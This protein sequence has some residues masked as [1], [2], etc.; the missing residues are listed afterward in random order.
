MPTIEINGFSKTLPSEIDQARKLQ[1]QIWEVLEGADYYE[2]TL[3][4]CGSDCVT[5]PKGKI[6]LLRLW[7][8]RGDDAIDILG[9]LEPLNIRTQVSSNVMTELLP[10]SDG[11]QT[12]LPI[13]ANV[14]PQ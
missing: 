3:L 9:R 1:R 6:V 12:E 2:D 11:R 14:D 10:V 7:L 13:G 8:R 4:I 5:S